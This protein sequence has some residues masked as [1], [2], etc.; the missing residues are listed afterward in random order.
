MVCVF[1]RDAPDIR[2]NRKLGLYNQRQET[3]FKCRDAPDIRPN[4]QL[5]F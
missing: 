3:F 5:G 1:S 2:P 4:R